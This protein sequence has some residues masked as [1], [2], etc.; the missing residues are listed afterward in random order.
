MKNSIRVLLVFL[1]GGLVG[2]TSWVPKE[3]VGPDTSI[4]ILYLLVIQ[5]GL[6]LGSSKNLDEIARNVNLRV[7][8]IPIATIVG[9]LLFTA[10][11]SVLLTRWNV[12]DCMAVGSGFAYYSLSSVL[13]TELK[14][15][16]GVQIATE[17]GTIALLSNI[18]RE[19]IGLL[20]APLFTRYFGRLA[21]ISVAGINSMDVCLPVISK[22]A[23]PSVV[24]MAV[25]H[26]IVLEMC[27]PFLVSMFCQMT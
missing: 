10:L 21:P 5:V 12:Y 6:S 13:I 14:A 20:G 9:T 16:A 18:I 1:L 4:T 3:W 2:L 8:V 23:G 11:A 17:L 26:G 15:G 7:L 22:Y 24:P 27:V 19:M 25:V